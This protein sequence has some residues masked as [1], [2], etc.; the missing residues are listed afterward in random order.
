MTVKQVSLLT[1]VSVRTLRYY[2]RIGLLRP[3]EVTQAGYRLYGQATLERLQHIL[4]YRELQFPLR[5]IKSI[6]NAPDFDRNRALEQQIELMKRKVEH[7]NSLIVFAQGV[8]VMG[9]G[10]L[11]F[12]AFDMDKID[13]YSQQAKVL[14]GKSEAYKE[15]EEKSAQRTNAEQSALG[16]G[17]MRILAAFGGMVEK[18]PACEEVQAQVEALQNYIMAHFYTCTPQILAGLGRMYAGGG[19]MTENIDA[20]GGKGTAAFAAQAIGCYG[21][22]YGI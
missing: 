9:V 17:L 4:L 10:T 21:S 6:L 1:G 22:K 2:D 19:A 16:E 15:F 13:E 18:D 3:D 8:H 11:D 14:W 5:E 7:L 20:A 12:S